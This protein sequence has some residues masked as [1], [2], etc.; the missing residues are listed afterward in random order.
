MPVLRPACLCPVFCPPKPMPFR[1][2]RER[3]QCQAL[4]TFCCSLWA[5]VVHRPLLGF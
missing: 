5:C 4:E 1:G 2:G 3:V